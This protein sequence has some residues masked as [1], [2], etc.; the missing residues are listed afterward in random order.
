MCVIRCTN[1]SFGDQCF[2]TAGPRL[3]N[4]LLVHLRQCDSFRQFKRLLKDPTCIWD[5]GTLWL[6]SQE[7]HLEIILL[8]YLLCLRP[9]NSDVCRPR[10]NNSSTLVHNIYLCN[11]PESNAYTAAQ[12]CGVAYPRKMW[13]LTEM[14]VFTQTTFNLRNNAR[15][16]LSKA[17]N[18][19]RYFVR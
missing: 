2:A 17:D 8:T 9:N 1:N 4:T 10:P 12:G 18:W 14:T 7:C 5:H 3:W 19:M 16:H 15:S 6:L 11:V 13:N